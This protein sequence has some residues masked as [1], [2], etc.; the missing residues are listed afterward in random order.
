MGCVP[1]GVDIHDM[2]E[3]RERFGTDWFEVSDALNRERLR[4]IDRRH[5]PLGYVASPPCEGSTTT[6]FAGALSEAEHLIAATRDALEET[7]RL[8]GIENVMGARSEIRAHA[9]VLRGA[10]FGLRTDRPRYIE[11]GGGGRGA[12]AFQVP[13]SALLQSSGKRLRARCCLGNRGRF[14]KLDGFG[15][16]S[17][18]PCCCGNIFSVIGDTPAFGSVEQNARAMGMDPGHMSFAR[19]RKALPP[20]YISYVV[21]QMAMHR[22]RTYYGLPVVSFDVMRRSPARHVGLLRHWRRGAGGASPSMG[23]SMVGG[24]ADLAIAVCDAAPGP[25]VVEDTFSDEMLSASVGAPAAALDVDAA[26][27]LDYTFAG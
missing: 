5:R 12:D 6:T 13:T 25:S 8:Y 4:A 1:Y 2:P 19:M 10:S 3:Y 7:G 26:R 14:P 15:R 18:V 22:L 9:V 17:P 16:R 11:A 27:E 21:G 23:L 24:P 20:A